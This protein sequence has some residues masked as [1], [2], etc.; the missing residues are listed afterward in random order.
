MALVKLVVT[1]KEK[2]PSNS[3]EQEL[4]GPILVGKPQ[5]G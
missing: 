4:V 3:S 2:I 1:L 5:F